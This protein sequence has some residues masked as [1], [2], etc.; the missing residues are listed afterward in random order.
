MPG[1]SPI[2][3]IAI[4]VTMDDGTVR[5]I[6]CHRPV[7]ADLAL[8]FPDAPRTF[9]GP[10][11]IALPAVRADP[12]EV[13]LSFRAQRYPVEVVLGEPAPAEPV[14]ITK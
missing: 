4:T 3:H 2:A 12:I 9:N 7:H 6:A 10:L 1:Q 8:T 13:S 11:E 5:T 14:E